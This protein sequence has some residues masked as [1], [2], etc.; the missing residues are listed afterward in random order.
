MSR[1]ISPSTFTHAQAR[2]TLPFGIF[3]NGNTLVGDIGIH[4]LPPQARQVELGCTL[5][6]EQQGQ[7]YA[8]EAL[9]S[10]ID[11]LFNNMAVHRISCSLD[12]CNIRSKLLMERLG[13]RQEA[14]FK[15]SVFQTGTGQDDLVFSILAEE[16]GRVS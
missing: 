13:L 11:F 4:F 10:L 15:Q 1:I 14:H 6:P 8:T 5:K 2:G 12:S 7:G 16:W 3:R 9:R